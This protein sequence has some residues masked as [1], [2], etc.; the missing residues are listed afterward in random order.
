M[1]QPKPPITAHVTAAPGTDEYRAMAARL[2]ACRPFPYG[3]PGVLVLIVGRRENSGGTV[4]FTLEQ[5]YGS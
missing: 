2:E 5:V 4:T 1:N 3:N